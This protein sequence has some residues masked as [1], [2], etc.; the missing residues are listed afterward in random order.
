MANHEEQ[1][2]SL[3]ALMIS[4]PDGREVM[5]PIREWQGQRVI[6][7]AGVD[8]GHRRPQSKARKRVY[9]NKYRFIFKEGYF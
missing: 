6:T 9:Q 3:P 8:P 7:L 1:Q 2:S 5:L 4:Y